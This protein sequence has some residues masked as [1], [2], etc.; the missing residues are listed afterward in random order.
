M[1][2]RDYAGSTASST[3]PTGTAILGNMESTALGIVGGPI[4]Y[5]PDSTAANVTE[6][7]SKPV[8]V[9]TDTL[10]RSSDLPTDVHQEVE[11]PK[12]KCSTDH[13]DAKLS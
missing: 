11:Q 10:W 8:D 1:N 4:V 13:Q 6:L 2:R 12:R 9:V 5:K 3:S 7:W